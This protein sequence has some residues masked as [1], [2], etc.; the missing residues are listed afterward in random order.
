MHGGINLACM[1]PQLL[2]CYPAR[3]PQT[4]W[5][6]MFNRTVAFVTPN[7]MSVPHTAQFLPHLFSFALT[8]TRITLL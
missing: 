2:G 6:S 5:A 3:N 8:I 4:G 1:V 7:A